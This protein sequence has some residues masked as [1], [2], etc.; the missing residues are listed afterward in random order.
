MKKLYSLFIIGLLLAVTACSDKSA[1]KFAGTFEDEFGN[2]FELRS[3]YTAT[4]QFA[5]NQDAVE[6]QWSDGEDHQRPFATIRYNGDPTY[7]YLRDG[8]LYRRKEDMNNGRCAI[9]IT[10]KD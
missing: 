6:T 8:Q 3:D 10:Y 5:G 2:R 9:H 1:H 4:I 7:Y